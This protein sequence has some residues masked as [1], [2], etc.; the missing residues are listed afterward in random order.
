MKAIVEIIH[1]D[2]NGRIKRYIRQPSRSF[3]ANF[4]KILYAYA[5][6]RAGQA[7]CNITDVNGNSHAFIP[8]FDS[9]APILALNAHDG[10]DSYGIWV[11]SG[12]TSPSPDD[13]SLE[14]KIPNSTL[15]YNVCTVIE[16]ST[17]GNV[18]S[19]TITRSFVNQ[20]NSPVTV[21]EVGLIAAIGSSKSWYGYLIARD[22]ISSPV[23]VNPGDTIQVKYTISVST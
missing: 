13:T 11:G 5:Y 19:M 2:R 6:G 21:S 4:L 7:C 12:T 14:N 3:V 1:R 16:P 23:T 15:H 9:G 18:T 22:V 17:S 8:G 10:E 20:G